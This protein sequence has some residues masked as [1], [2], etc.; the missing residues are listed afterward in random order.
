[1]RCSPLRDRLHFP[2]RRSSDLSPDGMF[3][4]SG[5][6]AVTLTGRL[7]LAAA[8]VAPAT[9]AE[10]PISEIMSH[11]PA[12]GLSEIPPVSKVMPLPTRATDFLADFGFHSKRTKRGARDE[13]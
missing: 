11:M 7:S 6:Y 2:T 4:A 1:R 9:A 5:K 12:P 3:S 10:P 8:M 13:P